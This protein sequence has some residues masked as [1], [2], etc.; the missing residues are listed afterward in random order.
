MD[1]VGGQQSRSMAQSL[2]LARP[3]VGAA[4]G[5]EQD[6]GGRL[7]RKKRHHLTAPQPVLTR[8]L[9]DAM[10]NSD[11]KDGLGKIYCDRRMLHP[12]SSSFWPL[13]PCSW[14]MMPL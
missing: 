3:V 11:L 9:T 1:I 2:D 8:H 7:L 10:R 12:D 13:R 5:L 4:T 6:G 14:H